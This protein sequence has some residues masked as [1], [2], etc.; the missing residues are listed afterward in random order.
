MHSPSHRSGQA[1]EWVTLEIKSST[2]QKLSSLL[3][4]DRPWDSRS[5]VLNGFRGMFPG[6]KADGAYS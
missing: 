1:V 2:E 6:D 3:L 5:L 4:G